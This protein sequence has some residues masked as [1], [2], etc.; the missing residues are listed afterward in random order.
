MTVWNG[1]LYWK[2]VPGG[3]VWQ[4]RD[5]CRRRQDFDG[6]MMVVKIRRIVFC[7]SFGWLN[8]WVLIPNIVRSKIGLRYAVREVKHRP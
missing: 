5:H 3:V 4:Q 1:L 8:F 2:I 7:W 6:G